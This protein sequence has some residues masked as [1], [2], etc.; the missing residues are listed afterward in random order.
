MMEFELTWINT[1]LEVGED[2]RGKASAYR[3]EQGVK[4]DSTRLK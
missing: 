1:E 3:V 4:R 2:L